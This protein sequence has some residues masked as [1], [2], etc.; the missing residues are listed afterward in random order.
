VSKHII[1]KGKGAKCLNCGVYQNPPTSEDGS[2]PINDWLEWSK[3][4][5]KKHSNCKPKTN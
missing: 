4:F 1:A 3:G 2:T 5:E